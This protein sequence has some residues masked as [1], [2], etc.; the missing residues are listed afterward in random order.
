[1]TQ[2]PGKERGLPAPAHVSFQGGE[3][4][5]L[6]K[7]QEYADGVTVAAGEV[8]F[9][10]NPSSQA[11]SWS[12]NFPKAGKGKPRVVPEWLLERLEAPKAH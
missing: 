6:K 9:T 11:A 7:A 3:K 2:D 12:V 10:I 5:R 8:G 1:M 4:V